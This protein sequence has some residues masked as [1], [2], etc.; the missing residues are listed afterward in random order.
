[1]RESKSGRVRMK[2]LNVFSDNNVQCFISRIV[3]YF[4]FDFV[5]CVKN[6][7]NDG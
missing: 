1:M 3:I 6:N 4:F 5:Q 2:E 7:D